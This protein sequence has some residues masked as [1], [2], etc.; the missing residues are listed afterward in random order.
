MNTSVN[1]ARIYS[2]EIRTEFLRLFRS[3]AFS[4]ATIGFPV[5]F[6]LLFGVVNASKGP[7]GAF[8]ARYLLATYSVFGLV[9]CSL[10]GISVT[11]ANERA[12]GWLELK[13]ASPMPASAYLL[14][15]LL[16]A[17]SFALIIFAVLLTI[18]HFMA[19]VVLTPRE[20][21]G[22]ALTVALGVIP[23]A[24]LGMM[25]GMVLPPNAATGLINLIYLPMSFMSGLWMPLNGMPQWIRTIAPVWPTWH[26]AHM[27]LRQIGALQPDPA[28]ADSMASHIV[29]LACFSV[30]MLALAAFF[31]RRNAAKG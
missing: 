4:L 2:L 15:K 18:G 20:F 21:A 7:E 8:F 29:Y 13:Q 3:K 24:A 31:F 12:L 28:K 14:S 17:I 22:L 11:L 27:A 30:G 26:V 6:Y 5:M 1:T 9:G 19:G 16:S 10:F 23:F 25:L